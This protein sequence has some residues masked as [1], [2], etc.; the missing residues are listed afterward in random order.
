MS[1][2]VGYVPTAEGNAA[3]NYAI[4]EARKN[5][6]LLVVINSSKGDALVDNRYAGQ[7]EMDDIQQR[8]EQEDVKHLILHP[9][10]GQDATTEVLNAAEAHRAD[11]IVIGLRRRSPVGKLFLGSTAQRILLEADC[12][13]VAVK[14]VQR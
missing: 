7:P 3:L 1:I 4:A 2:V 11:L 5:D 8:L 6:S 10:R 9:V 12:P 13:V 14:A